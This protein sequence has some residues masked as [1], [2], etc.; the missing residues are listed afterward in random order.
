MLET[1]DLQIYFRLLVFE[2]NTPV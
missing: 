1:V 2:H